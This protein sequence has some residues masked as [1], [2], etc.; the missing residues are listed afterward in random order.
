[1]NSESLAVRFVSKAGENNYVEYVECWRIEL[2]K[3]LVFVQVILAGCDRIKL[4]FISLF[5][6]LE[7]GIIGG[8]ASDF[9]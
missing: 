3:G 4:S 7:T 9:L 6:F 1:M 8:E 5:P 2:E